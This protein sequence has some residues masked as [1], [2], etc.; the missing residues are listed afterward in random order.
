MSATDAWDPARYERFRDERAQPFHDLLALL[1]PVPGGRAIDLGCGT[2]ELTRE[3]HRHLRTAETLGVD[4]SPAMLARSAAFAGEGLRF[5]EG[6]IATE[7][8]PGDRYDIVI[9]NAALQWID[10]HEA[11]LAR[12]AD[13]LEP[14]GQLAVQV[15]ANHDHPS[16]TVAAAVAQEPPFSSAL[17]GHV[18]HFPVLDAEEYATLLHRLGFAEQRVRLEVYLHVLPAPEDVVEWV[19]GTLLTDYLGRLPEE[20]REPFLD[21]YRERLLAEIGDERPYPFAFKRIL[22]WGRRG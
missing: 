4:S 16:H 17:A 13:A 9:S 18:R 15:P 2:G 10:G 12:L 5:A 22:M 21:R 14:G 8:P 7:P 11:L 6:D 19:H 3:L 1:E 20:L